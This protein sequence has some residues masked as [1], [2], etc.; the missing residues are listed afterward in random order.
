MLTEKMYWCSVLRRLIDIVI[1]LA[2]RN[3]S[4]RGTTEKL[5][6]YDNGNFLGF[7]ELIAQY[8]PILLEH[9][10][11]AQNKEIADHYLGPV[12]QN[13]I[14]NVV[15]TEVQKEILLE[16]KAA[17]YYAVIL[18]G[19]PDFSHDEQITIILCTVKVMPGN[20]ISV[21]ENFL[22]F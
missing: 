7:V 3:L 17:K 5:G 10:R 12:I 18:D 2:E 8:D 21:K 20:E 19:T 11:R 13:E 1:Y 9:S 15:G 14:I 16:V 6:A 4:F 22:G